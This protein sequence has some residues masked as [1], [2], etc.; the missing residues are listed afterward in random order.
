MKRSSKTSIEGM[1][2]H[3]YRMAVFGIALILLTIAGAITFVE[4]SESV[5]QG[6]AVGA[7]GVYRF[8]F[9]SQETAGQEGDS[10]DTAKE[11][12]DEVYYSDTFFSKRNDEY[13]HE[14]ARASLAL[15]MTAFEQ[16]YAVS[17]LEN[18]GFSDLVSYRYDQQG[19]EDKVAL[20]MASKSLPSENGSAGLHE[21]D[22]KLIVVAIRGGKYGDEW[23]S[24]GRVGYDGESFGYHYGF[25]EAAEDAIV[26]LKEYAADNSIDLGESAVWI[27]GF[28]RGAAVANV[29][30]AM[31]TGQAAGGYGLQKTDGDAVGTDAADDTSVTVLPANLFCYTF[32]SPSTVSE[33]LVTGNSGNAV[34]KDAVSDYTTYAGI[35]NIVNSLDIVTRLPMNANGIS[36][37]SKG[38]TVKYSWDYVK[39]GTTLSLPAESKSG[40]MQVVDLL[41]NALAFATRNESRYVEN[42]QEQ[43]IVPALKKTMGKGADIS[44]RNIG[45]VLVGALPGVTVFLKNEVNQLDFPAQ[46]YIASLLTG[47]KSIRL[48]KEHWP[49]TYWGWMVKVDGLE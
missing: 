34:N 27:T 40:Q 5:S 33:S 25:H 20:I 47:K 19:D 48:E 46:I 38:K 6:K 49:E 41:E 35:Y 24:N 13:N 21:P 9:V 45:T 42:T 23:G 16:E 12:S 18:L 3:R 43:V 22:K 28:S 8:S 4:N 29:M 2:L 1:V 15:S 31:L 7:S 14:L 32:A 30:G 10:G 39:Y 17:F 44:K 37:T 36:T 26:Q 11:D